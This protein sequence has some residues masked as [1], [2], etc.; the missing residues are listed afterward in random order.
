MRTGVDDRTADDAREDNSHDKQAVQLAETT[1][2]PARSGDCSHGDE[3]V[4]DGEQRR[5]QVCEPKGDNHQIGKVLRSSIGDLGAKL[6]SEYKPRLGIH[7]AFD[8]LV[9]SPSGLLRCACACNDRSV[10]C[11]LAFLLC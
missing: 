4:R 9:P 3:R 7:Y 8:D 11:E 6:Q 1:S 2:Q 5:L 10:A